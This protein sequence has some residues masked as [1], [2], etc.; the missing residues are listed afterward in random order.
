MSSKW[1]IYGATK[2]LG[3]G[4]GVSVAS[5]LAQSGEEVYGLCRDPKK[6]SQE[7]RF[8][9]EAVDLYSEQGQDRV[10]DLI[11]TFDPDVIWSACGA[12]F[13]DPLW[14][15]TDDQIEQM[16]D[17]NIRN[18]VLF[19]RTCAPSCCDG[20]P[21]LILTGSVAG[22]FEGQGAALYAGLKGFLVPFLRAQRNE[23]QRQ[24]HNPKLSLLILPAIQPEMIGMVVDG[25]K[26]IG[27]QIRSIEVIIS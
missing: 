13:A 24:G 14:L 2:G 22:V 16:V 11:R 19:C 26:Y 6:A 1:L 8:D 23:Y 9:L 10:K 21:H 17:A 15:L 5:A 7:K 27:R 20:G 4:I 25:L 18:H 12:G 3:S